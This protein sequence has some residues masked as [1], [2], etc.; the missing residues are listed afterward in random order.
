ML[1]GT[2]RAPTS[3]RSKR[4]AKLLLS[5]AL[6]TTLLT[7]CNQASSSGCPPLVTYPVDFQKKAAQELRAAG[8]NVQ[9]LVTDYGQLRDAC[10]AMK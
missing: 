8:G 10:R 6:P 9:V 2:G 5:I 1:Y 4:L 7:G 3:K